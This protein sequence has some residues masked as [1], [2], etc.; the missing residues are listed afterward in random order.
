MYNQ[1]SDMNICVKLYQESVC[2]CVCIFKI[3]N[4]PSLEPCGTTV[5]KLHGPDGDPAH[6]T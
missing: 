3:E 6:V 1:N 4:G 2:I 5:E